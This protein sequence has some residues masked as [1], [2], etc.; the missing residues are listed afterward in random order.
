MTEDLLAALRAVLGPGGLKSGADIPERNR[1]DAAGFAPTEPL[2]LVLPKSTDEVAAVLAL[3]NKHGQPVVPQGGMTGLVKGSHPDNREI[4]FSLEKMSG[5]EE[6]DTESG[7]LTALAGTP[8]QVVQEAAAAAGLMVGIDLGARG[9]CTIG[10]NVAT[11]AG[12][13]TV[14]RYGMTRR[15]VLGLE[16]VLADGR[17]LRG[18]NKMLKNNTGFD[19][20]QLMIG[21]EGTLGV[22]TRVTLALHPRP[23]TVDAA[24]VAVRG[25]TDAITLLRALGQRLPGGLLVYEA[26]W[27]E[28]YRIA[29][30]EMGCVAPLKP[31]ADVYVMIEAPGYGSGESVLLEALASSLEVG[32]I[33]DAVIARSEADRMSFWALR[34]SVYDYYQH[35]PPTHGFD[36]SIP[37]DKMSNAI[38]ALREKIPA[39]VPGAPW[40]VFGHLA[41]SNVH[42][43]VMTD[44]P[45]DEMGNRICE[46]VYGVVK[47]FE[48]SVSAEHGIGRTK[49]RY[50]ALSRSAEELAVMRDLKNLFDPRGILSPGR[51]LAA[52]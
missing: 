16:A 11:N 35:F 41:D 22:V 4:A 17:I 13:N 6:I 18:L 32:L 3:C 1:A 42:V 25:T 48:G 36:I 8:L 31:G 29:I 50:L 12:G 46:V 38:A 40:V 9:S 10:G 23:I 24:L 45:T 5:V 30:G 19:W 47:D 43:N 2:A 26:M 49:V 28:F 7:T 44:D 51:I 39:A 33:E 14:L 37:L 20:T 34:E 15:N 27:S 21:S 52:N